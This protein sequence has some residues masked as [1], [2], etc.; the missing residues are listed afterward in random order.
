[1]VMQSVTARTPAKENLNNEAA[2]SIIVT[3]SEHKEYSGDKPAIISTEY[4]KLLS[5]S[6]TTGTGDCSNP[7]EHR[8]WWCFFLLGAC[9]N[10][11]Y[12]VIMSA[13]VDLVGPTATTGYVFAANVA[14][15]LLAKTFGPFIYHRWSYH[16]RSLTLS[17]L[18]ASAFLITAFSDYPPLIILGVALQSFGQ[19]VGEG[20]FLALATL[21]SGRNNIAAFSAGL[22]AAGLSAATSYWALTSI[23]GVLHST[24]FFM[25]TFIAPVITV[26]FYMLPHQP[27]KSQC[28]L[29]P[30]PGET[31]APKP[32][33]TAQLRCIASQ[34][35]RLAL[36]WAEYFVHY[37]IIAALAPRL[38][39]FPTPSK[40]SARESF[41]AY[42]WMDRV[43]NFTGRLN[44]SMLWVTRYEA[45][46]GMQ[47]INVLLLGLHFFTPVFP[48][49]Q[50]CNALYLW[51]GFV[52]G[53]FYVNAKV[54]I[55]KEVRKGDVEFMIGFASASNAFGILC[56]SFMSVPIQSYIDQMPVMA[57]SVTPHL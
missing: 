38:Y 23:M 57:H 56:A 55:M 25:Y 29:I 26:A 4:E 54:T 46:C 35:K 17:I 24:V 20:S 8:E 32:D 12:S 36:L 47:V 22:A 40:Y 13:A 19:G 3:E 43:G 28:S 48:A 2:V 1:M 39:V 9:N 34:W 49:Y 21:Y 51:V 7:T 10:F 44:P 14:P 33:V 53:T 50:Y 11:S 42:Q 6:T 18:M 27:Q 31:A 15:A 41:V 45:L 16:A 5:V 37:T 52:T 30:V